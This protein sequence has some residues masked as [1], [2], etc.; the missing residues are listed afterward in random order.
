MP[1]FFCPTQA[2]YGQDTLLE[3]AVMLSG[4]GKRCLVVCGRASAKASGALGDLTEALARYGIQHAVFDEVE[5]NPK[6]ETCHKGG[7]VAREFGA[8]FIIGIGGGSPLD[9]AKGVAAFAANDIDAMSLFGAL[10]NPPLPLIAIPTTAGTGSEVNNIS[11]LT[12]PIG[13]QGSKKTY[14]SPASFPVLAFVDPRYTL[15]LPLDL[16][17]STALDAFCHCAESYFSPL[18]TN[19]TRALCCEGA[20]LVWQG[21]VK[22]VM[23]DLSMEV[24]QDLLCGSTLAGI[25][26]G[27]TGTGFPHPLGYNLSLTDGIPHGAACAIFEGEYLQRQAAAAPELSQVF[28]R[29]ADLPADVGER[30]PAL[31]RKFYAM[32]TLD[33]ETIA[34]YTELILGVGNYVNSIAAFPVEEIPAMLRK[35]VY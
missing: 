9:A 27:H 2:F 16:T 11:V 12:I 34:Q 31:A 6:V 5:P 8:E 23:G 1:W 32:P 25:S 15:S 3:N 20:K 33:D 26:I 24:R 17:V 29:T 19:V 30:I 28:Y 13:P 21:L 22:A 10:P 35:Y 4:L 7:R 14:R 18:A